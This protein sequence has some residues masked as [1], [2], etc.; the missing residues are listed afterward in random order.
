MAEQK[1]SNY[2]TDIM[3]KEILDDN[4]IEKAVDYLR[5]YL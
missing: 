2:G 5:D 3:S 1:Q 4:S